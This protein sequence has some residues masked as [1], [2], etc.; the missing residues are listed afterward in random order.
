MTSNYVDMLYT[1]MTPMGIKWRKWHL[2]VFKN[3]LDDVTTDQSATL[4]R[5]TY[6]HL[7]NFRTEFPKIE[8]DDKY[9]FRAKFS[10][11]T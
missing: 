5:A 4:K 6:S 2:I 11:V 3:I 7:R 1:D 10:N 8:Y 9:Y